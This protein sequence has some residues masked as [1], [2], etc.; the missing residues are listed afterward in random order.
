MLAPTEADAA[1]KLLI[2]DDDPAIVKLLSDRCKKMGFE[3]ETATNGMQLII[4]AR[5]IQPN[6]LIVDVNMP[7]LDGVSA[8]ARLLD[9][10]GKALNVIVVAGRSNPEIAERCQSMGMYYSHKGPQLWKNIE[11][12]LVEIYPNMTGAIPQKNGS[13]APD[14]V[15]LRPRVLVVDDDPAVG[16]FLA[17][18][19]RKLGVD[20][21]IASNAVQAYRIAAREKP[22]AIISDYEMPN[23]DARHLLA[24]LR[25]SPATDS[26][27]VIVLSGHDIDEQT[28]QLLR[29]EILGKSG[30][31]GV[32]KKSFEVHELFAA[33]ETFCAFEKNEIK[34]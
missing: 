10:G 5:Q 20:T 19:L 22:S 11:A 29:R 13:S 34:A 27:P 1:P 26:I 18:R 23:G 33:L 16:T 17:S 31:V 3:V 7:A 2:A 14:I 32:F 9:T 15:P 24:R 6:V 30:I 4:K 8:S 28:E 21:L 25:S 12:A